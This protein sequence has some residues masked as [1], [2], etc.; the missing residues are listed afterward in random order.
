M[1]QTWPGPGKDS[2]K[3]CRIEAAAA[4]MQKNQYRYVSTII[5]Q[6][7]I[8]GFPFFIYQVKTTIDRFQRDINFEHGHQTS[9]F[10]L[11]ADR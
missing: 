9:R 6:N 1:K 3:V 11:R 2:V 8:A 10:Q 5:Q 7:G 4:S